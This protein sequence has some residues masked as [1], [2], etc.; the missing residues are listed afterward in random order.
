MPILFFVLFFGYKKDRKS[1]L[2][3]FDIEIIYLFII[4]NQLQFGFFFRNWDKDTEEGISACRP[5]VRRGKKTK[6]KKMR[7]AHLK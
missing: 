1:T 7:K 6:H 4:Y 5:K 3:V 2:M